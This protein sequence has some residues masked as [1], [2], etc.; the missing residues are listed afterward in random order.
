MWYINNAKIFNNLKKELKE[1]DVL[2]IE[3]GG[4]YEELKFCRSEKTK[5]FCEDKEGR[6]T[7]KTQNDLIN[8]EIQIFS[9]FT[10]D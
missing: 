8:A 3:S 9:S 1:G 4:N 6:K 7:I 5:L 10:E 2:L